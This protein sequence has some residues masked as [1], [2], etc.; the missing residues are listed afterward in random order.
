MVIDDNLTVILLLVLVYSTLTGEK[1][2]ITVY[3]H[4]FFTL[5]SFSMVKKL[6]G[7]IFQGW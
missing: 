4:L 1:T 7:K 5:L 2:V 3:V 6:D